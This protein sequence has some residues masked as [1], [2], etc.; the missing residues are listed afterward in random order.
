MQSLLAISSINNITKWPEILFCEIHVHRSPKKQ[1][2]TISLWFNSIY[3]WCFY[4]LRQRFLFV[5]AS[6]WVVSLGICS[7]RLNILG[8]KRYVF[9]TKRTYRGWCRLGFGRIFQWRRF[10]RCRRSRFL[11]FFTA[12]SLFRMT[13]LIFSDYHSYWEKS[14]WNECHVILLMPI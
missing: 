13:T 5:R 10:W 12:I 7:C 8:K 3:Q 2:V 4:R 6:W 14:S 11:C 1:G 9:H